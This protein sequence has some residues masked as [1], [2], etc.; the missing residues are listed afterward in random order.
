M[1]K[2]TQTLNL[3]KRNPYRFL[4]IGKRIKEETKYE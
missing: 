2:G 3:A 1:K 4:Q